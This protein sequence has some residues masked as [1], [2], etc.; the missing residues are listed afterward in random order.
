MANAKT[1]F[2]QF[3]CFTGGK[4]VKFI[5]KY[6]WRCVLFVNVAKQLISSSSNFV[7]RFDVTIPVQKELHE[8]G[9]VSFSYVPV[10]TIFGKCSVD[11]GFQVHF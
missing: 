11:N 10:N 5:F 2:S 3:V 8:M 1:G 7:N 6:C 4:D 9:L